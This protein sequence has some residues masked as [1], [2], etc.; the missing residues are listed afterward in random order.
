MGGEIHDEIKANEEYRE[1]R[2]KRMRKLAKKYG[3]DV[4]KE[5]QNACEV[6]GIRDGE[7]VDGKRVFNNLCSGC[8]EVWYCCKEHQKRDWKEKH[9]KVCKKI[10]QEKEEFAELNS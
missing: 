7:F 10:R 8:D 9:K 6:C 5:A 2:L 4:R 1:E 3:E